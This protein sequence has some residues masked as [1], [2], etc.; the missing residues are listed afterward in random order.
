MIMGSAN[1]PNSGSEQFFVFIPKA[2]ASLHWDPGRL[3][4][5][6]PLQCGPHCRVWVPEHQGPEADDT[7]LRRL[8]HDGH[9]GEERFHLRGAV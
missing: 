4:C 3:C 2:C 6:Q 5:P 7:L 8:H 1:I 9:E